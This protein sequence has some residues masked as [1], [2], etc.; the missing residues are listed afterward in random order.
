M[1]DDVANERTL[2]KN[3]VLDQINFIDISAVYETF[4]W[5]QEINVFN[6]ILFFNWL[7]LNSIKV[8]DVE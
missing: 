5:C 3:I 6:L 4:I 8:S 1:T 2:G 7:I